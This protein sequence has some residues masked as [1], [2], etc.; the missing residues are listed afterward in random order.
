MDLT[1][2]PFDSKIT[3]VIKMNLYKEIIIKHLEKEETKVF[4]PNL[5]AD[6]NEI[7]ELKAYNTLKRIKD[8][9]E[10]DKLSDEECFMKIEYIVKEFEKLGSDCGNRHDFG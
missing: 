6:I 4:F 9:L 5:S 8:I 7:V 10:D 1:L 3:L 2:L